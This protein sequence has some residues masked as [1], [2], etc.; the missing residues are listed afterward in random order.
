MPEQN[1][2]SRSVV[3][4]PARLSVSE[5]ERSLRKQDIAVIGRIENDRL[6]LDVRTVQDDELTLIHKSLLQI[7]S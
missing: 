4:E 2:A 6:L 3:L 1:I 5:L 7:F